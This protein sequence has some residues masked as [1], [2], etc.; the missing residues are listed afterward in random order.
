MAFKDIRKSQP[1]ITPAEV[2]FIFGALVLVGGLLALNIYLARTFGGGEWLFLRWSAARAF[3]TAGVEPY[4]ATIAL[5]T[6]N[7]AFGREA[8]LNEYP[9]VLNDPFYIVLLYVPLAAL[10]RDFSIAQGIWMSISQVALIAIVVLSIRFAEWEPPRWMYM[11][12]LAF[13]LCSYFSFAALR[14]ASPAIFLTL[15]YLLILTAFQ[16]MSDEL[17]GTLLFLVAYHWETGAL[18]FLFAGVF[19]VANRR[20]KTLVGFGMTLAILT[21]LSII[22]KSGWWVDYA[23]AVLFDWNRAVDYTF[24]VTL[25]YIF[26]TVEL[27]WGRWLAVGLVVF[28]TYEAILAMND[29]VRHLAW[30]ALLALVLNQFLGFAMFAAHQVV[31]LPAVIMIIA[32]VWERWRR[33]RVPYSLLVLALA[34]AFPYALYYQTLQ[35]PERIYSDLTKILPPVLTLAGLYWM[36]WWAVRPPRIWADQFGART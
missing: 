28:L 31:L 20:W 1:F 17:A 33:R 35:Q 3:W 13:G 34:I 19:V 22:L 14:S 7:V 9:F 26:P 29:Y 11:L 32:L 23:R 36:R 18:F 4:G 27:S 25:S 5:Q 2:A 30:V 6:Q 10:F 24:M 8:F 12:L 21:V 16:N 15:I